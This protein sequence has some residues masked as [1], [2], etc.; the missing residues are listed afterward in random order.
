MKSG[1]ERVQESS[2]YM[3]PD[4]KKF[5]CSNTLFNDHIV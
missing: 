4:Q 3:L 5:V 2:K 1:M